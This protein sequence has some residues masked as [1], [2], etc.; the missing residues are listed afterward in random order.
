MQGNRR[1]QRGSE[2]QSDVPGQLGGPVE[3][4]MGEHRRRESADRPEQRSAEND[5]CE[6]FAP[7]TQPEEQA[8]GSPQDDENRPDDLH[9]R[10]PVGRSD[11][12]SD[13]GDDPGQRGAEEAVGR[14]QLG[15][16]RRRAGRGRRR[17]RGYVP[18][19]GDHHGAPSRHKR[20]RRDK[21]AAT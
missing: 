6:S 16:R 20:R 9:R 15:K 11:G 18:V 13:T 12:E 14:T 8:R 17:R 21:G 7:P 2:A 19:E 3:G 4:P 1:K 5:R 10:R